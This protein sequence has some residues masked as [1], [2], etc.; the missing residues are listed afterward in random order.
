VQPLCL[1]VSVVCI[2]GKITTETQRHRDYTE[3]PRISDAHRY[4]EAFDQYHKTL[5]L[6]LNFSTAHFFLARAYEAKGM[7]DEAVRVHHRRGCESCS[8]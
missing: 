4:E 5:E 3:N 7:Y 6:D 2:A 8:S 1:C